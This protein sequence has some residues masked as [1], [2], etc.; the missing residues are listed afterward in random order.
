MAHAALIDDRLQIDGFDMYTWSETYGLPTDGFPSTMCIDGSYTAG[1]DETPT[2]YTDGLAFASDQ[3]LDLAGNMYLK[4][5]ESKPAPFRG[6]PARKLEYDDGRVTWLRPGAPWSL[7]G[8]DATNSIV[9]MARN[10]WLLILLLI[11]VAL[12]WAT[13]KTKLF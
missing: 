12:F 3:N 7:V 13:S 10:N 8:Q 5:S 1:I 2:I 6:F 4:T 11:L 9:R